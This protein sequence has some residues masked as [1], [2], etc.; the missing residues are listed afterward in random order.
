[1][2]PTGPDGGG[3]GGEPDRL[4]DHEHRASREGDAIGTAGDVYLG[5]IDWDQRI[6][7][8]VAEQFIEEFGVDPRTDPVQRIRLLAEAEDAK[9]SLSQREEVSIRFGMSGGPG[10]RHNHVISLT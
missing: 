2:E 1:M 6:A 5:G 7:D 3:V 4:G 10:K 9:K 8:H